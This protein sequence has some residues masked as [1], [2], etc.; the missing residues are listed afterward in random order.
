MST[1]QIE[2]SFTA[3]PPEAV[4]VG[5]DPTC[6]ICITGD[7]YVSPRHAR[8]RRISPGVFEVVDMGSSNGTRVLRGIGETRLGAGQR[9]RLTRGDTIVVGRTWLPWSGEF[10]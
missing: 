5:A 3:R 8:V 1:V 2:I 4:V 10:R 9:L 7:P 6:E